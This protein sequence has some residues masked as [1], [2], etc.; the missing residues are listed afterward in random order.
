MPAEHSIY[1]EVSVASAVERRFVEELERSD[2]V[3]CYV[4]LPNWFTVTTPVVEYNPDWAIVME[5]R[6]E[7]GQVNGRPLLYLVRET[8]SSTSLADLRPDEQRKIRCGVRHV[9]EALS[10]DYRVVTNAREL[11]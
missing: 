3:Q 11:P 5:D 8:K 2:P 9:G 10:V 1:D 4:K 7:H 6:D